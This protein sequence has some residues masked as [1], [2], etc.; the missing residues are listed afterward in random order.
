M[1]DD[2]QGRSVLIVDDAPD[3]LRRMADR[4]DY[5]GILRLLKG[6]RQ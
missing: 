5:D 3:N 6:G 2:V 1:V 4:F